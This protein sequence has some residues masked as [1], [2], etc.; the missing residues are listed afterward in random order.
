MSRRGHYNHRPGRPR[1]FAAP[2]KKAAHDRE[3][4]RLI[5]QERV[6]TFVDLSARKLERFYR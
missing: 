4:F 6:V 2:S 3:Q 1:A 5:E